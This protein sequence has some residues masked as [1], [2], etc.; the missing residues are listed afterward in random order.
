MRQLR[1][2]LPALLVFALAAGGCGAPATTA[3]PNPGSP[4]IDLA[5]IVQATLAALTAQATPE[6]TATVPSTAT[7]SS[8][9]GSISG[10]L[11]YPA[12]TLPSMY[13]VAYQVGTQSYQYVITMAGQGTFKIDDLPP[14]IYHIVAYTVGGG[15]FPVGFAGGYT[16]AVPCGL[17]TECA[18]H[19]LIDVTVE[20]GQNITDIKPGDWYAPPGT[21]PVFPQAAALETAAAATGSATPTSLTPTP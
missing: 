3:T 4:T 2:I 6:P 15:G 8:E 17:A 1:V 5:H 11:T 7:K 12:D 14:G 19:S 9:T 21:F 10:S 20:P 18:D 13:V 16:K